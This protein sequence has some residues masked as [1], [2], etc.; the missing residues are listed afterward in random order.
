LGVALVGLALPVCAQDFDGDLSQASDGKAPLLLIRALRDVDGA[1][2]D[3]TQV[4][5][6]WVDA[7]QKADQQR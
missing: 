6:G 7:R 5:K 4:V 1:N 3:R 2:L